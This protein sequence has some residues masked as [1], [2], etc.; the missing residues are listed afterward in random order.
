LIQNGS[1]FKKYGGGEVK[2]DFTYIDDITEAI[3]RLT[4]E[5]KSRDPGYS[6]VVNIGGGRPYS[7]NDLITVISGQLDSAPILA[8][9][10]SN[11]NDTVYTNADVSRLHELTQNIPIVDLN[12]GVELTIAWAKQPEIQAQLTAWIRSTN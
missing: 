9:S 6:D 5:L 7:L 2:R 11:P 1:E 8:E 12:R 4:R 10:E 3:Q